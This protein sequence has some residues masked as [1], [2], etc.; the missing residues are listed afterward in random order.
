MPPGPRRRSLPPVP[1]ATP[2]LAPAVA[3]TGAT[4]R[5]ALAAIHNQFQIDPLKG[6]YGLLSP[7]ADYHRSLQQMTVLLLAD[8]R[9][10]AL[11]LAERQA[12]FAE[13]AGFDGVWF[14]PGRPGGATLVSLKSNR[15]YKAACGS[16]YASPDTLYVVEPGGAIFDIAT[17]GLVA[18]A[19]WGGDRWL[20]R[21]RLKLDS[22]SGLTLWQVWHV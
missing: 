8:P 22:G 17:E 15:G 16:H 21:V 20:V 13:V 1:A 6:C 2:L 11:S 18:G 4:L 7:Y 19:E 3:P 14:F 5:D 12:L 9:A 10:A